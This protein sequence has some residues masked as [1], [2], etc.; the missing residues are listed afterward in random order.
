MGGLSSSNFS[1]D[2]ADGLGVFQGTVRIVPSLNAPGFCLLL[3][4]DPFLVK[5]A[6]LSAYSHL[7]LLVR[8]AVQYSGFKVSFAANTLDPLFQSFK[9]D[10]NVTTSSQVWC[11]DT[12]C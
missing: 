10:F 5:F 9:A 7:Q 11:L 1:V 3:T 6:D 8:S 12:K 4:Q 2:T